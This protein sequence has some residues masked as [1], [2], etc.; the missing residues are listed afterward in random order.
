MPHPAR[1]L[2]QHQTWHG[3]GIYILVAN[4][5]EQSLSTQ[6]H[7]E[8][9]QMWHGYGIYIL[10]ANGLEQSL[11]TQTHLEQ[12]QMW[13]GMW[14]IYTFDKWLRTEFEHTNSPRTIPNVAWM[15]YM[16]VANVLRTR[17]RLHRAPPSIV[18][19][20]DP[21]LLIRRLA[22]GPEKYSNVLIE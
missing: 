1:L 10:V 9:H 20:R 2:E 11:S 14:Y 12:H 22:T 13:H 15:W 3:C 19:V 4:G 21:N 6:T 5:L 17:P 16:L 18:T 7:L 8:Q